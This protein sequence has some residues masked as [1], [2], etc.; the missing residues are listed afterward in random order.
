MRTVQSLSSRALVAA[1]G[2]VLVASTP[3]LAGMSFSLARVSR[4]DS[5]NGAEISAVDT[6]NRQLFATGSSGLSVFNLGAGGSLSA[7]GFIDLSGVIPAGVSSVSSVAIDPL[8]RGFGVAG[9]IPDDNTGTRGRLVAFDLN[10]RAILATFDV[11]YNPDHVTF[12]ADG[13]RVLIADEGESSGSADPVGGLTIVDFAGVTGVG[14]VNTAVANTFDFRNH[15]ANGVSLDGIRP[16]FEGNGDIVDGLEPEYIAADSTGAWITLQENNAVAR[17]DYAT[18][19]FTQVR[20]LGSIVQTVDASDRDGVASIDDSVRGLFLPDAMAGYDVAGQRFLVT[21]NEGDARGEETRFATAVANGLIDPTYLAT[22]NAQYGGN[23]AAQENLGRLDISTIDG[24]YDNDGDI[25]EIHMYGTRSFTIFNADTGDVVFD[26][27][28]DFEQITKDTLPSGFFNSEGTAGGFDSR[29]D[30]KGPEPEG[31]TLGVIA[32]QTFAFIALERV[33][34]V[35][36]YD[37]TDPTNVSFVDYL[38][39][40]TETDGGRSPEGLAFFELDG[41]YFLAVSYEVSN[42][43]E[44]FQIIPAPAVASLLGM[45]GLAM[46]RRRR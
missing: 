29:S 36:M 17:F 38:N 4:I 41:E 2:L 15:L 34:G 46:L 26:S 18:N 12:T 1:S 35:M 28:S 33:G 42:T 45:G 27:G 11:G 5:P 37:I 6:V 19:T 21:A 44:I 16:T 40:S 31:L 7:A 32:S 3:A 25:D 43:V 8:G 22:L 13:S 39:T 20:D 24:D 10:T 23:A 9:I 30:N 14:N